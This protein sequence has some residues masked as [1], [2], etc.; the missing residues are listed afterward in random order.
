MTRAGIGYAYAVA[1]RRDEALRIYKE[2]R[3]APE[4]A[5]VSP[6]FLALISIGLGDKDAAFRHLEE[7]YGRRDSYLGHLK[8]SPVVDGLRSDARFVDLMRRL[9]LT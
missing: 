7:A 4:A 2:L 1:G 6:S 3:A 5:M 8:V 9:K